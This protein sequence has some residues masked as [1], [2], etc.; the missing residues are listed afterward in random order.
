MTIKVRFAPSPTGL[1]HVGNARTALINWL[2]AR[3]HKGI[4]LLRFD[5]TD[6]ERT[7][8]EYEDKIRHDLTWLGLSHDEEFRQ[9]DQFDSYARAI[10]KL[11]AEGRLYPC[12]E[13]QEELALKRKTQLARGLP[14]L[15]DRAALKLT[16]AQKKSFED[17]GKKPHWRLRLT[18]KTVHWDDLV[19]GPVSFE[20]SN[21]SDPVLLREDGNPIYTLSSV[22]DDCNSQITHI[23]RGEDHVA[24]TAVQLQLV[25]ALGANPAQFTFAHLPLLTGPGGQNLSKRLGSLSLQQLRQDGIEAMALNSFLAKLGTSDSIVPLNT[26]EELVAEFDISH[27]SRS[28]PKFST[29]ALGV[30]NQ[31]LLHTLS[32]D[33]VKDRL[34]KIDEDFWKLVRE[35]ITTLADVQ[36][37]H[38][39]CVGQI[40]PILSDASFIQVAVESLPPTPWGDQTFKNW[41]QQIKDRTGRKGKDLFMPLR[42]ALT[43]QDHGPSL[44]ELLLR[45]GPEKAR[46]RLLGEV[47]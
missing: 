40:T 43:G 29:E 34:P 9:Q 11:K 26:L 12:Y 13:T 7:K 24:N 1:L 6:P 22:V 42:L 35:N 14:P 3:R 17:N 44:E 16:D 32:Y 19:R 41:T 31:K 33:Q 47:A 38:T 15:Y 36:E 30:V 45:I 23:I 28:S 2:F 46:R 5:D 8:V 10:E 20:G 27:F 4:F 18:D 37:W 21:L 39:V 25:E